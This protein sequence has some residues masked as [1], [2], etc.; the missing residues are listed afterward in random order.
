MIYLDVVFS[1]L[2]PRR[3]QTLQPMAAFPASPCPSGCSGIS[4]EIS[5]GGIEGHKGGSLCAT[6]EPN[7]VSPALQEGCV[8]TRGWDLVGCSE[9][10]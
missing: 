8:L 4:W 7:H 3:T 9:L 5:G 6:A 2:E 1:F 10:V